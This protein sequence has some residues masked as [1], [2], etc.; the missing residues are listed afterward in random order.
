MN[1]V[2]EW[3]VNFT[4]NP[5]VTGTWIV[6]NAKLKIKKL[7]SRTLSRSNYCYHGDALQYTTNAKRTSKNIEHVQSSKAKCSL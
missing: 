4:P 1:G 3:G 7:Y 2:V 5:H 6:M